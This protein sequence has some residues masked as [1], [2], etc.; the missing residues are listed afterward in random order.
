MQGLHEQERNGSFSF[1]SSWALT[2]ASCPITVLMGRAA[3]FG[4][5]FGGA[6]YTYISDWNILHKVNAFKN[7]NKAYALTQLPPL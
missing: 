6:V 1:D 4:K 7:S 3:G 2:D 5:L